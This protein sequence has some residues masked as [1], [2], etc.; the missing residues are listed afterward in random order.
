[1]ATVTKRDLVVEVSNKCGMNQQQASDFLDALVEVLTAKLTSG[2]RVSLRQLG[3]F[4]IGIAKAKK[5]R[6]PMDPSVE[7]AIPE[8]CNLRFRPGRELKAKIRDMSPDLL[9]T[10]ASEVEPEAT[11]Q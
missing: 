11:D 7:I 10:A 8:R 6:N 9:R 2:E 1:M 3:T 5:G 4:D